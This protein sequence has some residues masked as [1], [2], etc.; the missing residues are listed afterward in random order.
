MIYLGRK[1]KLEKGSTGNRF[2][3]KI[4]FERLDK[5]YESDH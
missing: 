4:F 2:Q 5:V 3:G 1:I